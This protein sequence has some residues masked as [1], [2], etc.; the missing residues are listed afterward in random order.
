LDVFPEPLADTPLPSHIGQ[1]A[2]PEG[3]SLSPTY[4]PPIFFSFVLTNINGVKVGSLST[5]LL[6]IPHG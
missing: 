3:F 4:I 2:F 1:F 6:T 5:V